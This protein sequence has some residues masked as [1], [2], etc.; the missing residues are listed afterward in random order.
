[1][2]L[3]DPAAPRKHSRLGLYIPFGLLAVGALAWSAMWLWAKGQAAQQMD[4]AVADLK[5][6]GYEIS[7]SQREI[8]GYP[9][10]M[11][12]TLTDARVREPSGWALQSPRIEAEA[13]MHALGHWMIAA[14]QTITFVRP[15][16]GPVQVSGKVIHAAVFDFKNRPPS[17][18]FEGVGLAFQPAPGARPFFLSNAERVE[19]HLRGNSAIDEGL[20]SLE[21]KNGKA[22]LSGLF[23]RIAA[24]KPISIQWQATLTKMSAFTGSDWPGAVRHWTDNGGKMQL[25]QG[26]VTAGEALI[27]AQGGDLTVGED[28]RL[29]GSLKV[30][31]RQAPRALTAMGQT[32]TIP[33]ET[34][35]AAADVAQAREGPDQVAHATLDF[36]AGRTTLGP[37]AIGPAPKVY[38][39]H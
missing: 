20:V 39:A 27:G 7:W 5:R 4:A 29:R 2:S 9:F 23:A 31:L 13:Y 22:Q 8:G 36:Q 21:V 17:F 32:G 24:D 34:A 1:M 6:A 11:D 18:D 35:Q 33:P 30:S 3:P 37:V 15:Q 38:E 16:G 19:F 26:G 12:V 28:G 25:R 14:P 10:R